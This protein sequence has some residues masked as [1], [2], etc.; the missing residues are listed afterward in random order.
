[1]KIGSNILDDV[2]KAFVPEQKNYI[3]VVRVNDESLIQ[4]FISYRLTDKM[5]NYFSGCGP[6]I[7]KKF[8]KKNKQ[9]KKTIELKLKCVYMV[10]IYTWSY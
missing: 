4:N 9:T 5:K 10:G 3:V 2:E 7:N 8:T 1:M 6:F